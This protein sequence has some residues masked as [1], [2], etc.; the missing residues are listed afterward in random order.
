MTAKTTRATP[1]DMYHV[2]ILGAGMA[3]GIL[4]AVLARNGLR[5]L[6]IDAGLHPRFAVGESTI[7]Y[8]S[9]MSKIIAERYQ[10]PEIAALASFA[11]MRQVSPM[12]GQKRH[13]GFVYHEEGKPQDPAQI[14]QEII[15]RNVEMHLFRQDV[16][17]YFYHA[18][19]RYGAVGH[20]STR[21][22][23][24]E[25]DPDRGVTLLSASGERFAAKYL[26]DGSGFRS[27][28]A[29]KLG[30]RDSPTRA[31]HHSRTLFTHMVNVVPFDET[32][33]ARKHGQPVPWHQ[34]TLHHVFRG[35]W[36]WVIPFDNHDSSISPLCSVGLTIDERLYPKTDVPPAREFSEFLDRFPEIAE[37]FSDA[38]SVR[39]WV[40]TDRLQYSAHTTV[41]DRYCLTAHAAGFTDAIYSRGLA[42]TLAVVNSLA[43]RLIDAARSDDWS[44]ERFG[45]I[46]RLQQGLF[47][48]H[49]DLAY[50]SFVG[51]RHYEL[52]NA[53]IRVW[54]STSFM[55]WIPL[56]KALREFHVSGN[57]AVLNALESDATPGLSGP[58]GQD[59]AALLEFTRGICQS[60][61]DGHLA[62]DQAAASLF[63]RLQAADFLPAPLGLADPANRT[64]QITPEIESRVKAWGQEKAPSHVS[65]LFA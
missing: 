12:S 46:D 44:T 60:V 34:G 48:V 65:P 21:I 26:V 45:Y 16:D 14:N 39:P 15:P 37:Q 38:R 40:G 58:A 23:D 3:G 17:A 49:D 18:A 56:E 8:T 13:F 6:L 55:T 25:L 28:V 7:P 22:T 62:A 31:R 11:A 30:L 57:E 20:M 47:N 24:I 41:G 51:F 9:T 10:V 52:W 50:S 27:P 42:N 63:G 29:E 35:G 36:L 59:I 4:G 61:E 64:P 33:A 43:G 5:V 1:G 2:A 19:V 54:K 53:I 32:A